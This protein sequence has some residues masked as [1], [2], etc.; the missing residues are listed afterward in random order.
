[1]TEIVNVVPG[2]FTIKLLDSGF[3][4]SDGRE[5]QVRNSYQDLPDFRISRIELAVARV[6]TIL[7]IL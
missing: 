6:A 7:K 4:R 5:I 1:M 2:S 3:R